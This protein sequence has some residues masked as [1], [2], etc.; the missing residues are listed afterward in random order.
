MGIG[1]EKIRTIAIAGHGQSGK[2]TLIENLA[3]LTG[4][5]AR[6][7]PVSGGKTLSD[8]T[9][10]EIERKISIYSALVSMNWNDTVI[11]F[12]DTPGSSDFMGE[13]IAA[14]RSAETGLMVLDAKSGVQIETIKYWRD[15][16]RRNKPRLVFV[17]KMDEDRADF[18]HSMQD[19]KTQ[20]KADVFAVTFPIGKGADLTGIVDVLHGVAYQIDSNGK[21]KEIP[22]PDEAKKQ[23]EE[24]REVLA[25]AAAE[26]DED[27][28]VK[29]I[30]EGEL[31][32]E[33]IAK[34]LTLAMRNN[35]IVPIFAGAAQ[36]GLGLTAL[37]R[38]ITEILPSPAGCLERAVKDGEECT[39]KI[40]PEPA[41]SGFIVKTANDQFSGRLSYIKVITGTLVSDAEVYNINEQKKERVGKLYRA[42]GK[43]LT[44]VK[45][46]VAG[47]VGVAVKLA[48]A[49]T[50]DTLAASQ[51]CPPFVK[52]RNPDPIYSL[53]VAAVDK[54]ND[55][56]LGEQLL[57]ACEEDMTLSFVYNPE[58][59][60][61][62]F[63]GMGD[64]HTSIVLDRIKKQ[65][66]IEIQT[67][68][69]RIAYRETIR[70]KA[71]AEYTH[72]KQSGGHGQ[73]G[74]VVLAI[75]PLERGAK[76][77]FTNAVFGGAISKGYIPGVE[78]GVKEAMENGVMAG[79]PVVDVGTTVL[80]G[81]EHPVDSSEM[82]FKIA[83]R[84][85]FKNAMRNAGPILLEP[86]MNLTVYVETAYLGD[87]MSDLSSRRGRILGQ[88]QLANGI[89]EIRA[90]VPHKELLRYAIDLRSM[91]SGTGSFEMSFDH[92]DPIS[93][94]IADE[95]V[96]AAKAFIEEQ[97]E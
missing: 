85:A 89:E 96:A 62:V 9:P 59:K 29:F 74:R 31:S 60:Q 22:I 24:M 63:S 18:N 8:Y 95:V 47:D 79:Y 69:P 67:S 11:N 81:K 91:T 21:E 30:D 12:W 90:Q 76:Y 6:A 17:N 61:N 64:L 94:K 49:K 97:E 25:G 42:A 43:K 78:K 72:K 65:T 10:E 36:T 55:D 75:E 53:A 68:I 45:E 66:K 13:V 87:I 41:F 2:T 46:L 7:E 5:I 56:K 33:E 34:G 15:L 28:L 40:D 48:A 44:E 32:S 82:A 39:I 54:K 77:S 27:L 16:D 37:L 71:Q 73:F 4:T 19:V 23:Y 3:A 14:F 70:Q 58:T 52:L 93:G 57:R 51:D 88:S 38:F 26:G 1:T 92:Y 83:A 35:R 20:F 50:N 86:I 84:N 80:D